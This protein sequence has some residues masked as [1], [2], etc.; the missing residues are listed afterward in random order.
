MGASNN[1]K[2]PNS[3]SAILTIFARAKLQSNQSAMVI[4]FLKRTTAFNQL[5]FLTLLGLFGMGGMLSIVT[6]IFYSLG[7]DMTAISSAGNV[8]GADAFQIMLLKVLQ[9]T[10]SIGLF[11]IPY[12]AYVRFIKGNTYTMLP[13]SSRLSLGI[14]FFLGIVVCFPLITFLAEW[15]AGLDFPIESIN[16]WM[17]ETEANAEK[18]I[19]LFLQMDDVGDLLFNIFLIA[20]LPAVGEELL[21][22]GAIQPLMVRMFGGRVHVAI[23]VTAF[24]FSFIHLQFLGFFPRFILGAMLGYAAHW[25][26][27]MWAPMLGH[28]ANNALAVFLAFFIGV[29]SLETDA[30][31]FGSGMSWV[32]AIPSLLLASAMM[33]YLFRNKAEDPLNRQKETL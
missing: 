14:V 21:F 12:Y 6:V 29:E 9:I 7:V 33:L 2:S 13:E 28:F 10:Q 1:G 27:S 30:E 8:A 22:R 11:F 31:M 19:M 16:Q 4:D 17:H 5:M 26:G 3:M 18:L 20:L 32:Y 15:N 25:T 23:W 24:L